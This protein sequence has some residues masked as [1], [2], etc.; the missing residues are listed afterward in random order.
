MYKILAKVVANTADLEAKHAD[1]I[2]KMK[3]QN[4][5]AM[6]QYMTVAAEEEKLRNECETV[7]RNTARLVADAV[8]RVRDRRPPDVWL[9][10][11]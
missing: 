3:E 2:T 7:N 9:N 10:G 8:A 5:A 6:A 4:A 11:P 1:A